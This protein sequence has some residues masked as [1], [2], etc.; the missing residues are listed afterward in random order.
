MSQ[1][2]VFVSDLAELAEGRDL[3][4]TIRTLDPGIHKYT[5]KRVRAQVSADLKKHAD[6]LQ[7]RLG[8]GQQQ[9]GR[10]HP[11]RAAAPP[12]LGGGAY[13]HHGH[14]CAHHFTPSCSRL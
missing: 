11:Q 8:R 14:A 1:W 12:G 13:V 2:E 9:H 3:E 4:L 5:Y 10:V 7:V 6:Q